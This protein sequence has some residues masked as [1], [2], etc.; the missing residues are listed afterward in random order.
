[1]TGLARRHLNALDLET[2]KLAGK[3]E[4]NPSSGGSF[5]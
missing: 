4:E 5:K 1:M 2:C 3:N